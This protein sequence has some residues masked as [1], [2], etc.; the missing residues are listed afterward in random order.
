MRPPVGG[1]VAVH[2]VAY[3]TPK[4]ALHLTA[5]QSGRKPAPVD[6]LAAAMLA[7]RA[8]VEPHLSG[9]WLQVKEGNVEGTAAGREAVSGW[10]P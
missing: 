3:Q 2:R 5:A 1:L 9:P 8:D 4:P 10:Q 6:Q 7:T